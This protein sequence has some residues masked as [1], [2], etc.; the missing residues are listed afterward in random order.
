M[1]DFFFWLVLGIMSTTLANTPITCAPNELV[2]F[3][4]Y[5]GTCGD[6]MGL[7]ID[8]A[9]GYL[10]NTS[11]TTECEFCTMANTNVFLSSIHSQYDQ[12]WRNWGI[13]IC[14]IAINVI[15][16]LLF[17]WLAR[18]PKGKQGVKVQEAKNDSPSASNEQQLDENEPASPAAAEE[19]VEAPKRKK[20]RAAED[21]EPETKP[22]RTSSKKTTADSP[23]ASPITSPTTSPKAKRSAKKASSST[24][25]PATSPATSPTTKRSGKKSGKKSASASPSGTKKSSVNKS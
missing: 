9:G 11:S 20:K 3:P 12:R 24:T 22:K 15:F 16:C 21:P 4:P 5:N 7:W 2:S 19:V 14:Y 17:Y 8:N 23:A 18:V 10:V 13:F 1:T 25:S 6:Y